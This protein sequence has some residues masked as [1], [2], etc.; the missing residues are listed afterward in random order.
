MWDERKSPLRST[1]TMGTAVEVGLGLGGIEKLEDYIIIE[2]G[3]KS[4]V[5]YIYSI[6]L[7]VHVHAHG[8]RDTL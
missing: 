1:I 2:H 5:A 4:F 7:H 8:S 3:F 6:T